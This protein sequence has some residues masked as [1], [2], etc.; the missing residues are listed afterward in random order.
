MHERRFEVG[1]KNRGLKLDPQQKFADSWA[2]HFRVSF[3]PEKSKSNE[4]LERGRQA[5]EQMSR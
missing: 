4:F 3:L 2:L 1:Q 5:D